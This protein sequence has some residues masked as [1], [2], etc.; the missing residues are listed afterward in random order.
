MQ[1]NR[2]LSE[3][4]RERLFASLTTL[5]RREVGALVFDI[6][7]SIENAVMDT[8]HSKSAVGR[9]EMLEL[10]D[11]LPRGQTPAA[12]RLEEHRPSS[13]TQAA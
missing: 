5:Q 9:S 13:S 3:G 11:T 2:L 7:R 1:E 10:V 12:D 6:I 8:L 4:A